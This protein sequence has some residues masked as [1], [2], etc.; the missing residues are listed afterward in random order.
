[1][2]FYLA[3]TFLAVVLMSAINVN[4][5]GCGAAEGDGEVS[6]FFKN[7]GCKIKTG[8][9]DT[10]EASKPYLEKA[11]NTVKEF[12]SNVKQG[13]NDLKDKLTADDDV[14]KAE[15]SQVVMDAP[16]EKV[17]LAPLPGQENVVTKTGELKL[18]IPTPRSI[19]EPDGFDNRFLLQQNECPKGQ[20]LDYKKRCRP[21][22]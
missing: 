9:E 3:W 14:P 10:Y 17:P 11:G 20:V 6:A 19:I 18:D 15:G 16:T 1:M 22:V 4:A 21:E 5:D 8:A 12:G 7:L 13:I 2:K